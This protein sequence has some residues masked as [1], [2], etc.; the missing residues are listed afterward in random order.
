M[1]R[2][3][4]LVNSQEKK[5]PV[6]S[7]SSSAPVYNI[8]LSLPIT[9]GNRKS[10]AAASSAHP[11]GTKRHLRDI[12]AARQVSSPPAVERFCYFWEMNELKG[13]GKGKRNCLFMETLFCVCTHLKLLAW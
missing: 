2:G 13:V 10:T 9:D 12:P 6:I 3:H 11:V 7:S 4:K 8:H 5:H 1:C